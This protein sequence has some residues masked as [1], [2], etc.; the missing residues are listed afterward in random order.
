MGVRGWLRAIILYRMSKNILFSQN[1]N[2][3]AFNGASG[4]LHQDPPAQ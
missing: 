3:C 1:I 2:A 4:P